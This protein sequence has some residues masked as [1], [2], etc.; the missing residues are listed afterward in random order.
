MEA[1]PQRVVLTTAELRSALEGLRPT[2]LT[3]LQKKAAVLAPGTGMEPN[4]LLQEAVKRSLEENGGRNCPRDVKPAIFLGNVMKSIASHARKEW[5]R[6]TPSNTGE[7]DEIDPI[8][9]VPDPT[10]SPEEVVIRHLDGKKERI[11]IEAMFNE[12]R[13]AQAIVIGIMEDWSPHEIREME[14]MSKKEYEAARK[15]MRRKFLREYSKG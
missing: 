15:R 7:G 3:R 13:K 11:R 2:E 9:N 4:D 14:P 5:K 6:E 10:P 12:D 8:T 1:I